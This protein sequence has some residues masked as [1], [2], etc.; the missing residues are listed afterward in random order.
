MQI[1]EA[2]NGSANDETMSKYRMELR[3]WTK[4]SKAMCWKRK[5][6][7]KNENQNEK[8]NKNYS[9]RKGDWGNKKKHA[10]NTKRDI[11]K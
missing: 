4:L 5:K 6:A 1:V 9:G 3:I 2:F 8:E 11:N 7:K 10:Y